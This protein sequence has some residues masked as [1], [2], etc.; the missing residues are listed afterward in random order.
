[1]PAGYGYAVKQ[2]GKWNAFCPTCV[3]EKIEASVSAPAVRKLTADGKVFTPYDPNILPL[4]RSFP[5]ARWNPGERCWDV[6]TSQ[7]DRFRVLQIAE[8]LQLEIAPELKKIE[9]TEQAEFAS[10]KGL[11]PFQIVGVQFLSCGKNRLLGDEMGLGKTVQ[12]LCG[13][14]KNGKG[15]VICPNG[16]KYNWRNECIKWRSDLKPIVCNG[17]ESFRFPNSGEVLIINYEALPDWLTA[18]PKVLL[19]PGLSKDYFHLSEAGPNLLEQAGKVYLL[20]NDYFCKVCE[21]SGCRTCKNKGENPKASNVQLSKSTIEWLA[22]SSMDGVIGIYDE[23]HRVKNWKSLRSRRVKT[24]SK[25]VTKVFALT[26]TPLLTRPSDLYGVL[27]NCGMAY[28][29]FGTWGK[30]M[31]L[32]NAYKDRW[33]GI[34]WGEPSPEVPE[35]LR[36]VMLRRTR[37]EVLPDLPKKTYNTLVI[38]GM[39][40][41][42][43]KIMDKLEDEWGEYIYTSE[44]LPPF[45]E[46]AALRASLA[47]ERIPALE[48]YVEDCEEEGVPLVVASAHRAPIDFLAGRKGWGVITGSTPPEV[49]Q[50]VMDSFQAG[51]LLGVG[52]TIQAGGVGL[53]LTRAW[54]MLFVDRDWTPALNAQCEDRICR[55]GQESDK[56]QID[57]MTS[58]HVLDGHINNLILKKIA[59]IEASV[60]KTYT[61][62]IVGTPNAPTSGSV[63]GESD[64]EYVARMKLVQD[65][66]NNPELD[67]AKAKVK[68]MAGKFLEKI[69][70]WIAQPINSQL[71]T[72]IRGAFNVMVGNDP[73]FAMER[74][75]VGFNKPDSYIARFLAFNLNTDEELRCMWGLLYK[76]SKQLKYKFPELWPN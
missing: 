28:E 6:S 67:R 30:F 58:D 16:L 5:G 21:G 48:E 54:K 10:H 24:L 2:N 23:A 51:K 35:R 72:C 33:G 11:Y 31:G 13:I 19:G 65:A 22:N 44:E 34:T 50:Q 47:K 41:D 39:S 74:N 26:G 29:V 36:R 68:Q 59:L 25:H 7:S 53:T 40:D 45:E 46:F 71:E 18:A 57:I 70:D 43:R 42:T 69:G 4:L 12:A 38:N 60:E 62:T 52:L 63:K 49:R 1:M 76:Y 75:G 56:I 15:L 17:K 37:A 20:S 66:K 9:V 14:P 64:E 27:D 55:I 61:P 3:P 73:D 32:Y 8:K